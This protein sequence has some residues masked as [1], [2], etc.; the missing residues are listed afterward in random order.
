MRGLDGSVKRAVYQSNS[1]IALG[2]SISSEEM[3]SVI[4]TDQQPHRRQVE[5]VT[6]ISSL[7]IA[8]LPEFSFALR[9]YLWKKD[10]PTR[11]HSENQIGGDEQLPNNTYPDQVEVQPNGSIK[12][13]L[14]P[15]DN[16]YS[17]DFPYG[18]LIFSVI[19]KSQNTRLLVSGEL[20]PGSY[21]T[22]PE[23][24]PD[25]D[26][27][28]RAF[29][30]YDAD[31]IDADSLPNNYL[32]ILQNAIAEGTSKVL[33]ELPVSAQSPN[34]PQ[35]IST[36]EFMHLRR[37]QLR[38][39]IVL[40][41]GLH[42]FPPEEEPPSPYRELEVTL[43]ADPV[44]AVDTDSY[45]FSDGTP[46]NQAYKARRTETIKIV[47]DNLA[48]LRIDQVVQVAS[49]FCAD[50]REYVESDQRTRVDILM[51]YE[52]TIGG[53]PTTMNKGFQTFGL[54]QVDGFGPSSFRYDC[55]FSVVNPAIDSIV[56]ITL[57]S[58][59]LPSVPSYTNY[60]QNTLKPTQLS[61]DFSRSYR[62]IESQEPE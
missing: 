16:R 48:S 10:A 41:P 59:S 38:Y 36:D 58:G 20:I 30:L 37:G 60:V 53:V 22:P 50:G 42:L 45:F 29:K 28:T 61:L 14:L 54:Y 52:I 40:V 46:K 62:W 31:P 7:E 44:Y 18:I 33:F 26:S 12:S 27:D 11:W 15:A 25:S 19:S 24:Y 47:T 39:L 13:R 23:L 17:P 57:P 6:N 3:G 21:N 8:F 55:N 2:R 51:A 9:E 43:G 1:A 56:D 34:E 4:I 5:I 35:Q 32:S 49:P